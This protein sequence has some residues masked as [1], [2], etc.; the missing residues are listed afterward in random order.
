MHFLK[1]IT[2]SFRENIREEVTLGLGEWV[3]SSQQKRD[4]KE[5]D[6][7]LRSLL[8]KAPEICWVSESWA[9][10]WSVMWAFLQGKGG[11]CGLDRKLKGLERYLLFFSSVHWA[12]N[13]HEGKG[14]DSCSFLHCQFSV[15]EEC[16]ERVPGE[17]H[18]PSLQSFNSFHVCFL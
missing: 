1:H 4:L 5:Q 10:P 17:A 3:Q 14:V 7:A 12:E 13:S 9:L 15:G 11:S 8:R 2:G 6:D 18:G 16:T